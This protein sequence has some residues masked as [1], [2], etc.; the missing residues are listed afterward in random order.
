MLD[1]RREESERAGGRQNG[2]S[3][4]ER[5]PVVGSTAEGGVCGYPGLEQGAG[6]K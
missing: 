1:K 2:Q 6:Q 4:G 3:H 5:G